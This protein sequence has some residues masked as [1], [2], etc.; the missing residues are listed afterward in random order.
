MYKR[1]SYGNRRLPGVPR[2]FA[3]GQ[4][5]WRLAGGTLLSLQVESASGYAIDFAQTVRAPGYAT[6][7]L[8]AGGEITKGLS[9]FAEGRNLSD[10]RH[11]AATGV[12]R[13]VTPSTAAQFLPGDGRAFYAGIDWRFN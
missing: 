1:Q 8:K 7:G 4:L 2:V 9:W 13:V 3:R 5:G 10:R 12:V 6:W 11:A